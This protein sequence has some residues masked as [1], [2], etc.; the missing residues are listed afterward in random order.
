MLQK[1]DRRIFS[2]RERPAC[3]SSGRIRRLG[4]GKYVCPLF[5]LLLPALA[6][7]AGMPTNELARR[8]LDAGLDPG[9]CYQVRDLRFSKEDAR[10]YLTEGFLIFGKPVNGVRL[11]AVFSGDVEG[12]DAELLVMPP[13][14]SERL[15]LASF[16][17]SPNLDEHLRTAVLVFS[18]DTYPELLKLIGERGTP[19]KRPERGALLVQAWEPVLRNLTRS[20]QVRI[21]KD[22][23]GE[24]RATSGFFYGALKGRRLGNFDFLYDPCAADQ[25]NVGQVVVRYNQGY[26]D[27]WTRFQARSFRNHARTLPADDAVV[28]SYRIQAALDPE[29]KLQCTTEAVVIPGPQ[30]TRAL[31][32]DISPRMRVTEAR[33]AGEPAEVFQPDSIRSSLIRG[34]QDERLLIVPSKPLEPGREYRVEM[35]HSGA[36]ISDAGNGVYFVGARGS[37]YP[38]RFPQFARYDL[39]FRYPRDLDLLATGQAVEQSSDGEWSTARYRLDTPVRLAGF[40]L[41][42]FDHRGITRGNYTVDVYA[43]R[44]A[45]PAIQQKPA[46]V[47]PAPAGP[48]GDRRWRVDLAPFPEQIPEADPRAHLEQFALEI[49]SGL[50]FMAG[51]FGPPVLNALT[52]SPIPGN[53]GQG[54]PGLVYLSTLA[55]LDPRFRLSAVRSE[56]QQMFYSDIL[57]AHEMAHQWWG[58]LVASAGN[59]DDWLMEALANYSAL[60]YLEQRK[61]S[62]VIGQVLADYRRQLLAKNESG[63]TIE[64]TGPII[65]GRRLDRSQAPSAWSVITYEKGSW[66]IHMLR[67]RMGDERFL[68]MLAEVRRRYQFKTITTDQFRRVAAEALPPDSFDPQLE[69]FFDQWVYSTGIPAIR[70]S[71]SVRGKAP[72]VR[73]TGTITETGVAEDFSTWVPVEIQFPKS[74]PVVHWVKTASTSAAFSVVLREPPSKVLLDPDNSV[75]HQ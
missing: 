22:L 58:N 6:A 48:P 40:N 9:E 7:R 75:L 44:M 52:V 16:A 71:H 53:F 61:G 29:L 39:S 60:L 57:P 5:V 27:L 50:E 49:A 4:L 63:G 43:N 17:G 72:N 13:Y 74:K 51:R 28:Q 38:H 45:E 2:Q 15:S 19:R 47:P 68:A 25:I 1:E 35:K 14:R 26:F 73:V 42:R 41:G 11:S 32:F 34:D 21:V 12:G 62:G 64:S 37:W 24:T 36:V 33:V 23:L 20:F 56:T 10:L 67:R 55:Y 8:V 65:W 59:E 30:A 3:W 54:F 46:V 66:I 69:A 70:M 31:E 18:D